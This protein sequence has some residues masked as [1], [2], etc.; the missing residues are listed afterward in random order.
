MVR[1]QFADTSFWC[2]RH[3][4]A[5]R[6]H[7]TA[8][9]IQ[10]APRV[11]TTEW[12]LGETWTLVSRR[13]GHRAAVACVAAIRALPGVEIEEVTAA[14]R[15]H[16]WAW[17]ESHDEREYSFVDALS[18]TVMRRLRIFEALAFDGD[19]AAAGFIEMRPA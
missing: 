12:V 4:S 2:A 11:I 8:A 19:F 5:D 7:T 3:L 17:L 9:A 1:A 16:A 6:R 15:S 13:A 10:P 18:F 14:D